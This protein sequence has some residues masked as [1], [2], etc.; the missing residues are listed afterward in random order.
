MKSIFKKYYKNLFL[1]TV[2][3]LSLFIV[4]SS[5]S[6]ASVGV[7]A[8]TTDAGPVI[9][10]D[11]EN[12]GFNVVADLSGS[13]AVT[14]E[15]IELLFDE[16]SFDVPMTA[17][18]SDADIAADQYVFTVDHGRFLD[19]GIKLLTF[20]I[21]GGDQ[22]PSLELLIDTTGPDIAISGPVS[23]DL[24]NAQRIIDFVS[25]G[26]LF[27]CSVDDVNWHVCVGNET[28]LGDLV[29]FGNI[30]DGAFTLYVKT[31]DE[32]GNISTTSESGIIKDDTGPI[33]VVAS[34]N[35]GY[36]TDEQLYCEVQVTYD[37]PIDLGTNPVITFGTTT[38][39]FSELDAGSWGK[40]AEDNDVWTQI[41]SV[42]DANETRTG[43]EINS[44]GATDLV[45]NAESGSVTGYF[46]IDTKNPNASISIMHGEIYNGNLTQIITL[47]YDEPMDVETTPIISF[48]QSTHWGVQ[49]G[50]W[51]NDHVYEA[52]FIHDGVREEIQNEFVYVDGEISGT[53]DVQGNIEMSASSSVFEIDTIRPSGYSVYINQQSIN[54]SNQ[55]SLS[56]S[57]EGAE[58][59]ASYYYSIIG[60][61]NSQPA[62]TGNGST[63][64]SDAVIS[65]IDVSRL[66][67][68]T[69]TLSFYLI[70]EFG[71]EGDVVTATVAKVVQTSSGVVL[72]RSDFEKIA[73]ST[74]E[75]IEELK[76]IHQE[77]KAIIAKNLGLGG[78]DGEV[79]FESAREKA[80]GEK[81]DSD[82]R[83][84][85]EQ[86]TKKLVI[87]L[88]TSKSY[89]GML[90]NFI[91]SGVTG[92]KNIGPGE[93]AG[94]LSSY[95][96]VFGKL[97]LTK[98]E[99]ND[100][101]MMAT[102]GMP[103]E[104]NLKAETLGKQIFTKIYKH[105]YNNKI[106]KHE[107]AL[108]HISY[109]IMVVHR[110]ISAEKKAINSFGK[111]FKHNPV[112][113]T[114]WNIIRAIAYSKI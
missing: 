64:L 92:A 103:A 28:I 8:P 85:Y 89:E 1:F 55:N 5:I 61:N 25:D 59:G 34:T 69:L 106:K 112:S 52:T 49:S 27:Q 99:W 70:N 81:I 11:E 62:I 83:K 20:V 38:G 95:K 44:S 107:Q 109:G 41:F 15:E 22:S 74:I 104:R 51:I 110:D 3:V 4:N 21:N 68:G 42:T 105:N 7:V 113:A 31:N 17:V 9:N 54:S 57:Y 46:N 6:V 75:K 33:G 102:G 98:L 36:I 114:D 76:I 58:I 90:T 18:L 30:N 32:Y 67:N 23:G 12:A 71:D 87:G 100:I 45:G 111:I 94:L 10:R 79:F 86:Y 84:I 96:N 72:S 47:D 13:G 40:D 88:N 101:F 93:R 19:D 2:I 35:D 39:V 108:N 26:T 73:T 82:K 48:D 60:G 78:D 63:T 65:S 80:L 91:Y 50:E 66:A 37:E 29:E 77:I 14:G 97:P 43:V 24:V 16:G 56:F 53:T